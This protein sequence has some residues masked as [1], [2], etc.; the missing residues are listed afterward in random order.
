MVLIVLAAARAEAR[1]VGF[2]NV[3]RDGQAA[4]T[5][6]ES[7][8]KLVVA[9]A[10]GEEVSMVQARAALEE[11]I[12]PGAGDER[13]VLERARTQL[14]AAHA[15]LKAFEYDDAL[16]RLRQADA[17]LRAMMPTADVTTALYEVNLLAGQV[18]AARSEEPRALEAFRLARRLVPELTS[19]DPARYRPQIVSLYD[20]AG[21]SP[22]AAA[23]SFN[24]ITEPPGAAVWLDGRPAGASPIELTGLAPGEHYLGLSLDGHVPRN[25]RIVVGKDARAEQSY[26]LARLPAEQRARALRVGLARPGLKDDDYRRGAALLADVASVDVL[27]LVRSDDDKIV[28][29][30][31]DVHAGRLGAWVSLSDGGAALVRT[32]PAADASAIAVPAPRD[33]ATK[34]PVD[35][36]DDLIAGGKRGAIRPPWYRT[37]WGMSILIGGG[38]LVTGA[39]LVATAPGGSSTPDSLRIIDPHWENATLMGAHW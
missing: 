36:A 26:L 24:V 10:G 27:V 39:I 37:W 38:V 8:R 35:S 13:A 14:D 12:E 16:D 28:A 18:Y 20:K 3:A 29:A 1:R 22:G 30:A 23:G 25:E 5:A 32:L 21:A 19:L 2:A 31:W 11:P 6:I 4:R 33:V 34:L 17:T 7:S 9:K 15:A